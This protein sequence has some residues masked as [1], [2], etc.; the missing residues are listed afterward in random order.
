VVTGGEASPAS[1]RRVVSGGKD[2]GELS[3]R[4]SPP[5]P[6]ALGDEANSTVTG[7][8]LGGSAHDTILS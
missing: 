1:T 4:K 3:S 5:P 8:S 2:S 6:V 7:T